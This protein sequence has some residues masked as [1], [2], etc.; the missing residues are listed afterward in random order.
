MK[1]V[2]AWVWYTIVQL[3]SLMAALIG[4]VVLIPVCLAF[5]Y[6]AGRPAKSIKDG[7]VID[8]WKWDWMNFIYGN[9]EDGV[10]GVFARI[11]IN[12]TTQTPYM[13]NAWAPW[14]A[15][16]W[17]ALRNS[18]DNLKYVFAWSKGPYAELVFL[19]RTWKFG[20]Q[21]ENGIKVPVF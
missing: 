7:R 16:C 2:L 19:G 6:T 4:V 9:P 20:W 13:P 14:R 17:S 21:K 12:G 11:W 1:L 15:Y 3:I 8:A 18:A 10:S 5:Q